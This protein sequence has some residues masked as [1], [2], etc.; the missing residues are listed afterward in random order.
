MRTGLD[1]RCHRCHWARKPLWPRHQ[2]AIGV[3]QEG[4]ALN[5]LMGAIAKA[6]GLKAQTVPIQGAMP[7]PGSWGLGLVDPA[8]RPN[9]YARSNSL[10]AWSMAALP[11][12]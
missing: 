7:K 11:P 12:N 3:D 6:A 9:G 2:H 5:A 10:S 8:D 4:A 1:H